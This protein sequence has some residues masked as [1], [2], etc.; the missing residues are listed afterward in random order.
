MSTNHLLP[1]HYRVSFVK[2]QEHDDNQPS[3]SSDENRQEL[4]GFEVYNFYQEVLS[5][6][7]VEG[8]IPVKDESGEVAQKPA[9]S[10]R[11]KMPGKEEPKPSTSRDDS[12][13]EIIEAFT[14]RDEHL[15]LKAASENDLK[16]VVNYHDRGISLET[17]DLFGW[18]ALMCAA[19]AGADDVVEFLVNAGAKVDH[20]DKSGKNATELAKRNR[21][22]NIVEYLESIGTEQEPS[23]SEQIEETFCTTC[24]LIHQDPSHESTIVHIVNAQKKPVEGHGYRISEWSPGYQLLKKSGWT[25]EKGLGKI[26]EG[27]KYPIKT[28]L[29]R[30]RK[31][32]GLDKKLVKRVTHFAPYDPKAVESVPRPKRRAYFK[33]LEA[34]QKRE[35][36][37]EIKF[38]RMLND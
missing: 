9:P 33:E 7:E 32:L 3:T 13:I 30:D 15:F 5:T 28:A 1:L 22:H 35:K 8:G 24:N 16:K 34:K 21:F 14:E 4:S 2:G 12:D 36:H 11:A 10:S 31:G 23:D 29:K 25:E 26:G 38:R 20:V 37:N 18:T 17:T 19:A 27:R 6:S